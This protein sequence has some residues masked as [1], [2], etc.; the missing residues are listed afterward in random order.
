VSHDEVIRRAQ[1]SSRRALIGTVFAFGVIAA[2]LGRNAARLTEVQRRI[3]AQSDTLRSLGEQ[4]RA[5]FEA[6]HL[7]TDAPGG[8]VRSAK[9]RVENIS[10]ELFDFFLWV[11]ATQRRDLPI[12]EVRYHFRGWADSLK[13]STD[14]R[15]GFAVFQRAPLPH[16]P[17]STTVTL[18]LAN[19]ST[20]AYPMDLCQAATIGSRQASAR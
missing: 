3:T 20:V 15:T 7:L 17:D 18:T 12:K 11:D 1:A 9:H 13:L 10:S 2:L 4:K 8:G 14:P 19:D 6:V 5:L 16:C